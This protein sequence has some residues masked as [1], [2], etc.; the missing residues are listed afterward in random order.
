M[1][2][3]NP[4]RIPDAMWQLWLGAKEVIPDVKL[5]GIYADTK[6]YHNTRAR[7]QSWLPGNYSIQLDMDKQ[8]PSDKASAI[9]LTMTAA[10]MRKRTGYLRRSALDPADNRL[11]ALREFIGTL[12]SSKVYCRIDGNAGLGQG[13]GVDD[14]TRDSTHLWHIHI[15]VLRAFCTSWAMLEPV[16]SVLSGETLE[17]WNARKEG[18]VDVNPGQNFKFNADSWTLTHPSFK[19]RP[20]VL[21]GIHFNTFVSEGWAAAEELVLRA[22][23]GLTEKVDAVLKNQE[24]LI[25]KLHAVET[26][27]AQI[28]ALLQQQAD[29]S[30]AAKAGALEA[31]ENAS[32]T[33][34]WTPPA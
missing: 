6:G 17:E 11:R 21:D 19:D 20:K 31:L 12:D 23:P 28:L 34:H 33:V 7:L 2:N 8:G 1:T 25:G 18:P 22:V 26:Q 15:S 13:R 32:L 14:W 24:Y 29:V 5:G 30:A 10:E 3:P 16:L 4:A 9:D 27:N